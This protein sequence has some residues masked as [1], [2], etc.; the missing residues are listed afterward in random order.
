[1]TR[2]VTKEQRIL[3]I[4]LIIVAIGLT[5]LLYH[6]NGYKM[7]VLNLFYLP[8]I[9]G[10]F[11]LGRYR[12]GILALFCVVAAS[13]AAVMNLDEPAIYTLPIVVALSIAVWGAVLGM[14]ALLVGHLSD[15]RLRTT[16]EL[17]EAYIGVVEVMSQYLQSAHPKLKARAV[18]VAELSQKVAEEMKLSPKSVEDI[19]VAALLYDMGDVE[20]T[21]RVIRRAVGSLETEAADLTQHTFQ[22]K[23]LV[24]S[25]GSVLSGA[26]SLLLSRSDVFAA[27]EGERSEA[28]LS[29]LPLGT[30]ILEAVRDYDTM[31]EGEFGR[32]RLSPQHA[33]KELRQFRFA[34]CNLNVLHALGRVASSA[35]SELVAEPQLVGA[36]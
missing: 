25:L 9:L 3:E 12:A 22:G 17:Q 7:V 16:S 8:V 13:V 31:V 11:H 32:P 19:R 4:C 6:F 18:R 10:A 14:S 36:L 33:L 34:A 27:P 21:A 1:M 30:Q 26:M 24:I 15:E 2:Q 28:P 5:C 35:T 20:I 23:D 29:E